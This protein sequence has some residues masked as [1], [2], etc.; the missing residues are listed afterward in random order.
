MLNYTVRHPDAHAADRA[1]FLWDH[2]A[3]PLHSLGKLEDLTVRIAGI[4]GTADVTVEP[5][6]VLVFC[7]DHGVVAENVT[8]SG[9][10]VTSLVALSAAQGSANVNLMAGCARTDVYCVDMGM[11]RRVDHPAMIRRSVGKGTRNMTKGPAMTVEEAERAIQTGIDLVREMTG[12]GYVL[13]CTGEMGIGNT[14]AASAL[15]CAY[16]GLAP[17]AAVG[18]GAGLSDEGLLRK[19]EA[20][21]RALAANHPDSPVGTLAAFGGFEIAAMAGAF[22]GG[23]TCG[24]PVV[25]DGMVSAAAALAAF[26]ICPESADFMLPSHMSREGVTPHIMKE[27]GLDPVIAADMALGEGTGAVALMPLLDMALAVYGG[28]HTFD[29]LGMA[30]YTPQEGGV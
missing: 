8:Q 7:A 9:Q 2:V 3:K 25:V 17:E 19:R 13:I 24:V 18:R 15:C 4:R 28:T 1:R 26:R 14:T 12:R 29:A 23:L 30:A 11:A 20:V 22:L 16:L 6:C 10:E 21:R 5:R 27:L